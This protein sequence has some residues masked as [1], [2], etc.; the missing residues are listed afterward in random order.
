MSFLARHGIPDAKRPETSRDD[1]LSVWAD[2]DTG[3]TA[4]MKGVCPG[5][6]QLQLWPE[7]ADRFAGFG[8][9]DLDRFV[10]AARNDLAPVPAVSH[11]I[12]VT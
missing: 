6:V 4:V 3:N 12:D 8:I 7:R 1:P 11:A 2:G 10:R 5:S 9:P